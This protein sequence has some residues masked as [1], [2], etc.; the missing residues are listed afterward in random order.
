VAHF[1]EKY[2]AYGIGGF[3]LENLPYGTRSRVL[4]A[5]ARRHR[6]ESFVSLDWG[7]LGNS[8]RDGRKWFRWKKMAS[9][10]NYGN[11]AQQGHKRAAQL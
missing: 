3:G 6:D 10:V 1:R 8:G 9:M 5:R 11:S 2:C 4:A 7:I